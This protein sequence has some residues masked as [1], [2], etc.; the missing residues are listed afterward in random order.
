MTNLNLLIFLLP[1]LIK[2]TTGED[3]LDQIPTVAKAPDKFK[4][5]FL[6][7]NSTYDFKP[8]KRGFFE[9]HLNTYCYAGESKTLGRLLESIELVLEI[10]GDD[11]TQY[12]GTT[13]QEVEEHYN[14]HRSL[15]SFNLF[16]QKRSRLSLSPFM[17]Q[18]IGIETVQPYKVHLFH[19][20][21]DYVRLML[22]LSGIAIFL[23]SGILST[24][25]IF[26]YMTG[27]IIGICSSFLLLIWLSGKL[28]PRR[29]MMYGVLIGGWTVGIYV[30]R[31]LW[32]NIQMIMMT[33]HNYVCW[34]I[35]I[36]GLISFF[37]C[38][39]WGPP[40]NRRSKNIIKWLL[41]LMSLALIYFSSNFKE[42]IIAV[43]LMTIILYYF[44]RVLRNIMCFRGKKSS[45]SG[46]MD[47]KDIR[48][49]GSGSYV[50]S[51]ELR[52]D[53]KEW[54]INSPQTKEWKIKS[55][56]RPS[57]NSSHASR[58]TFQLG[59]D[60]HALDNSNSNAD[61]N[62]SES[63]ISFNENNISK[64]KLYPLPDGSFILSDKRPI[65]I[66]PRQATPSYHRSSPM[67]A[68]DA[69]EHDDDG[70]ERDLTPKLHQHMP[71]PAHTRR[72]TAALSCQE[73]F[74]KNRRNTPSPSQFQRSSSAQ[75]S[76]Q[77][78]SSRMVSSAKKLHGSNPKIKVSKAET[79]ESEG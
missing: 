11:Y 70:G 2:I 77:S 76:V 67:V 41:Q 48:H 69:G 40:K 7:A 12:E 78:R 10:E 44:P 3:V 64:Q 58:S 32:D 20:K 5:H 55:K 37:L 6:E 30:I 59:G 19:E 8:T 60:D 4:V 68:S 39:R 56:S 47:K 1:F 17:Q 15:F 50:K 36:T 13:P 74:V 73:L 71:L 57:M 45:S 34:Y 18:C 42:A 35:I 49:H 33:Y 65:I 51:K 62:Q 72:L 79:D 63:D 54:R 29:A 31:M 26:Y 43:I 46:M 61:E 25:A 75:R 16:S 14:D 53:C 66:T 27:I 38:Y 21:V 52:D 23:F 24:N 28:M 22:L 9:K